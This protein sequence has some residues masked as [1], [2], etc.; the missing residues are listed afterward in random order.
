MPK[1]KTSTSSGLVAL[2]SEFGNDIFSTDGYIL[3]C[4]ICDINVVADKKF[5]VEQQKSRQEHKNGV[6]RRNS[7]FQN[8]KVY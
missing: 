2:V 5:T 4:K 3:F 8:I 6:E 7:Q 1:N